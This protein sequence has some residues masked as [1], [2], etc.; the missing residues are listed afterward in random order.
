MSAP[1]DKVNP[2]AAAAP[3]RETSWREAHARL[4]ATLNALPDLLFVL[5]RD[6]RIYD[7]HA[8]QLDRL[9]V[10]PEQFLGR[11]MAEV[12]PEPAVSIVNRAIRDAVAQGHHSGSI[13][14]LPTP[15][16]ARWFEISL[17]AQGDLQTPAGRL[18]AIVRDIT[19]RKRAEA[20]LRESEERF[21]QLAWQSRTIIFEMDEEGR[22]LYVNSMVEDVLGYRPEEV[23]GR[24]FFHDLFPAG[25]R[26]AYTAAVFEV[27]R[28][29]AP[30][31]DFE[32]PCLTKDGRLI[33]VT[34]NALPV[35]NPDGTLR[36]YRG[37]VRDITERKRAEAALRESEERFAQNARQTRTF[38]WELD[39]QGLYT[40]VSPAVEDVLGYRPEEIIGQLH[41]YDLYPAE[42]REA[43]QQAVLA[44]AREGGEFTNFE[45]PM[46]AKD[47]RIVWVSTNAFPLHRAD[48]TLR[49]YRGSDMDIDRRKR[50]EL[51]LQESEARI[52][53]I[54]DNLPNGLVYQIDSGTDGRERRFTY[55]SQGVE[56]LHGISAATV[57]RDP[58][59][60]Y[61]QVLEEDRARVAQAEIHAAE[62]LTPL[63]AEVRLRLPAGEVR[64]RLFTSAPRRLSSGH[65]VWDGVEIDITARKQ[66]EEALRESEASRRATNDNLPDSMVYQMTTGADG[67]APRYTYLSQ[68][69][70]RM[71]GVTAAE[72]MADAGIMYRQILEE[73]RARVAADEARAM[74]DLQPFRCEVRVR[75]P[76]GE[77]RWR[78]FVSAPR[79]QPNGDLV[80]DG[81][82]T[83]ITERKQAEMALR[84][85]EANFKELYER[86]RDGLVLVDMTG[87][88]VSCNPAFAALLGYREEELRGKHY[89]EITPP[90]WEA[91]DAE[92][93]RRVLQQGFALPTE[94]AYL[95]KNGTVVPVEIV[96]NLMRDAQ[97]RPT[98][99]LVVVRDIT[100]RKM[101]EEALLQAR[102]ELERR[103]RESTAELEKS[104]AAL[105]RSEEQF[106]QMAKSIQ[107]VF[108]L[109]DA[110]TLEVL[111][112]SP[113]Y[114]DIWG[115]PDW[116]EQ[117][118]FEDWAGAMHPDDRERNVREFQ[119]GVETGEFKLQEYRIVRPAG[120]VR[121][122]AD[123][124]WPIRDA[125]GRM[126][127]IAG[128]IRDIT[129][130][131]RLEAEI[132]RVAEAERQRIGR[133]LHDS[134]GQSLTAI[135]YL[136]DA[137]REDLARRKRPE[138]KEVQKL[139]KLIAQT[140]S[141][142]HGLARGLLLA[143]L[144]RG[145][146]VSALQE[147]A[148]RIRERFGLACQYAGP[149]RI[150]KT[151]PEV[152]SQL[153]RIAQEA[154]TNA[155][156]HGQR[157][158]IEI[159]LARVPAGL[160]LSVQDTGPGLPAKRVKNAGIGLDIMRY[161]SSLIGGVFWIDSAKGKG[162]TVNCLIPGPAAPRRRKR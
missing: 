120:E 156:K 91:V 138:A 49:G 34:T 40:F 140:A 3:G 111:Y 71:H 36:S 52:R 86:M 80:W 18:V 128:V 153:Y 97:G 93:L 63:V 151:G 62:T 69:V 152:A 121:W 104:R 23:V 74:A 22:C 105:A 99:I 6:G 55:I 27:I 85:S 129:D 126:I 131:R 4:E 88:L 45:N 162:T 160:H 57:L 2:A 44:A 33:W 90:G 94:K 89:R 77:V 154:A 102:D 155:A 110:Q 150:P 106:R 158:R 58:Q 59:A 70:A 145:G 31:L 61:G 42:G 100:E 47:G 28:R 51:A 127:R 46:V 147:L 79:R 95:R 117:P 146:L 130:S 161:R 19:E 159:R 92:G 142:A 81:I 11:T 15:A 37:S 98:G 25:E 115:R 60:I 143:D 96:G 75:L 66:A 112:A 114:K 5:D 65:L 67:H 73:D 122:I 13:Y 39:D 10:P 16:G 8:P 14:P 107:E 24:L 21:A 141:E 132:L 137:V 76:L 41:F 29:K 135:G 50:T 84:E 32:N 87:H 53:A 30:L 9:Y 83:D 7:F 12:L 103:V 139:E 26:A 78:H 108:Y 149:V 136:A 1:A 56:A 123:Q 54:Q 134:L 48:G 38:V 113:A 116:A 64:W 125:Q 68:G 133:D 43:Y 124:A 144:K 101:V 148:F 72:L 119:A 118:R 17:A 35:L 82:E 157:T 20:A 109:L